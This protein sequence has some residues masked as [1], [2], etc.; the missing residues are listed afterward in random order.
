M[1]REIALEDMAL[2]LEAALRDVQ[3]RN[4]QLVVVHRGRRVAAMVPI[5]FYERWFA[6]RDK[7]FQYFDELQTRNQAHT[8]EEV[9]Q[10]VE[11][12]IAEVRVGEPRN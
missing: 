9:E 6:E 3:D 2:N 10:D 7:A 4:N 12:A 1:V 11:Q 5:E 8:V